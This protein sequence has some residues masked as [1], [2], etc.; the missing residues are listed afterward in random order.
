MRK[1]GALLLSLAMLVC[2]LAGCTPKPARPEPVAQA[3]A[4][5]LSQF[6][7]AAAGSF[8]DAPDRVPVMFGASRDGMQ[9]TELTVVVDSVTGS[10]TQ[11]TA[12]FTY[13]WSLPKNRS[14]TYSANATLIDA[15]GQ[16][17]IRWLP[18]IVHPQLGANQ[19][20]ELRGIAAKRASV[21]AADG[22]PVLVPATAY[23]VLLD[24]SRAPNVMGSAAV[25]A[26]AFDRA[27][28]TEPSIP[29]IDT[30]ELAATVAGRSTPYSVAVVPELAGK[31]I[32]D[33][34]AGQPGVIVNPEAVLD[35]ADPGFAPE[36]IG[37]VKNSV[38]DDL[39]GD[40]GWFVAIVNEH[41]SVIDTLVQHDPEPAPAIRLSLDPRIQQAAQ[42]AVNLRPEMKTMLVAIRPSNG[43]IL[44]VAQTALA[45]GDGPVALTGQYP[46]GSTFKI[47]T[48]TAGM[49]DQQ[50]TPQS[51]VPC[52]GTMDIGHRIVTNYN[53]FSLGSVPLERAF[54]A[55][56]NTSF[57]DISSRLAPGQL[58]DMGKK[59]GLG[60]DY[61]ITG[62]PTVTGSV[63]DGEEL[64][65]R[66][67][68]GFGQGKD[69]VSP[70]GMALVA[71]TAAHGA[72][73]LP[74]LVLGDETLTSEH[75]E[76]PS[77]EAIAG[78]QQMMRQVV[79]TG[80]ARGMRADGEIHGKTGEAEVAGGSHAWFAGYRNDIAFATLIVFGG[81]SESSVAVTDHFLQLLDQQGLG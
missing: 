17:T 57:A 31:A 62:L 70:F 80:T 30:R 16:W 75:V 45:D 67:E 24:A 28:E 49:M 19:H 65:D 55:S 36:I 21:I 53:A 47:I 8:T 46:P 43:A 22:R 48:A 41:G 60:I 14:V 32:A 74:Q 52:P 18:R 26:R 25:I 58:K 51:I 37:R 27:R 72:T 6:D 23:R 4:Q 29:V 12:T 54:A 66:T 59:F 50:L 40:R 20:L 77:P 5:A 68:A 39:L 3:F 81:G 33:E 61:Q 69:L 42:D 38:A 56:C 63:P 11:A 71:A 9:A 7:F 79:A 1:T 64:V 78:L 73:P 34:L 44:A 13:E 15:G 76:P 35:A 2:T 10:D